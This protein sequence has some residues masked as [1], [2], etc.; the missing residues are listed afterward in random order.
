MA[1]IL[2]KIPHTRWYKAEQKAI[3]KAANNI[4]SDKTWQYGADATTIATLLG[5]GKRAAKSRTLVYNKW[6]EMEADAICSSAMRL[7]VTAALG[8]QETSGK[9]VFIEKTAEA[10]D[11]KQLA[12][13]VEEINHDLADLLNR[14]AFTSAYT[15]AC[16]GDAYARVY[17]DDNGVVD[18]YIDELV[19]PP[20]VQPFERGSKT[21]GY[22]IYTGEKSFERLDVSQMARLK[23][24]RTQWVPQNGVVEKSLKL[25][26][27]EDD[28]NSIQIMPSMAGGSLLYSGEEAYDN[29][30]ASL[31]GIVG[32]RWI[33]AIDE[34]ILMVATDGMSDQ[35]EKK[36][37]KSIIEMKKKSKEYYNDAI[38]NGG[39]KE[40][41]THVVPTDRT[42]RI[43]QLNVEGQSAR[44]GNL[45][46]ED[47]MLHARL[48]AGALGHDLAMLGFA[49]QLSGGFGEGVGFRLSAQSAEQSRIIRHALSGFFNQIIDIHTMKRYGVVFQD[50]KRP[51]KVNFYGSISALEAERQQS[52]SDAMNS[53]LLIVQAIQSFK[54][55][56]ATKEMMQ[57]FLST[58]LLLDEED[59]K[60]YAAIVDAKESEDDKGG[61]PA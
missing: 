38:V 9:I 36:W 1:K 42:D 3:Q 61:F 56:G 18:L 44:K 5:S 7:S 51:W 39:L 2:S 12:Q 54:D 47:I 35:D 50:K 28:L 57:S 45:E 32:Q 46:I 25:D 27:T 15:G 21:I 19:R 23:M 30:T 10:E 43:T 33:D 11:N 24:P 16:F 26:I 20:L 31:T 59:A 6:S 29:L 14:I 58:Q 40:K 13:I 52:R 60:L 22:A 8:G 34:S 48:L 53:G 49:D 55:A 17:T 4:T 41:I 37:L